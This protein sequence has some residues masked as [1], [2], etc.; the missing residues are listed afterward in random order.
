MKN[1]DIKEILLKHNI[2]IKKGIGDELVID[3]LVGNCDNDSRINEGHLYIN[4]ETGA[5]QCKKCGAKGG[6][7]ELMGL[8]G[9]PEIKKDV[10][11]S[12]YDYQKYEKGITSELQ[13]YLIKERGLTA[14]TIGDHH[15]GY[16]SFYRSKWITIPYFNEHGIYMDMYKLRTT[17]KNNSP[18]Y[19]VYPIGAST[20]L[21]GLDHID[22]QSET[23]Y[24]TEGEFDCML[25]HQ[26]HLNAVSIGAGAQTF[27]EDWFSYLEPYQNI[28]ICY[29]NDEAGLKGTETLHTKLSLKYPRKRIY[30]IN[31]PSDFKGK[32]I[33]DLKLAG[34]YL[35]KILNNSIELESY[36]IPQTE[37]S[38]EDLNRILGK[39]IKEDDIN[40]MTTFLSILSMYTSESQINITFNAP[41]STGKSYIPIEIAKLFPQEDLIQLGYVSPT[42]FFHDQGTF[43]EDLNQITIDFHQKTIIF[44]DQPNSALLERLRPILSHDKDEILVKIT[45]KNLKGG[46]KTKN[47]LIKGYPVTVFCTANTHTDEQ[48]ITRTILLSPE[49]TQEKLKSGIENR[50]QYESNKKLYKNILDQDSD[51][52][53]LKKRILAIKYSGIKNVIVKDWENVSRSFISSQT[54]LKPHHQRDAMKVMQLISSLALL[55]LWNRTQIDDETIEA[56]SGDVDQALR[57]WKQLS[58]A[59]DLEIPPYV[60]DFLCKVISLYTNAPTAEEIIINRKDLIKKYKS[61][62]DEIISP[63]NLTKKYIEPLVE[64]GILE[65]IKSFSD[66]RIKDYI[67][68]DFGLERINTMQR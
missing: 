38:V 33:T 51:R 25:L 56:S 28:C 10:R 9:E 32:D 15:L 8:L 68:T 63:K 36:A 37:L 41:S 16:A 45:D 60:I 20:M 48:E 4:S 46:N 62:Y 12:P 58:Q 1:I 43:N 57:I 42:A 14:E 18:K 47:V 40:K 59:Q 19:R 30:K 22:T 27:K 31:F 61:V 24:I 67:L 2:L 11:Y 23:L 3:C 39:T 65:E 50:M 52:N 5:F 35:K 34:Y 6:F 29:D 26:E 54:T 13:E 55:N 17:G 53:E 44:L 49:T 64:A 21:Y 66:G 7:K